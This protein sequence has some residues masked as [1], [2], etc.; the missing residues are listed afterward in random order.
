MAQDMSYV[1]ALP[2][3]SHRLVEATKVAC[4][5]RLENALLSELKTGCFSWLQRRGLGFE[6][7]Q[8]EVERM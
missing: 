4:F 3:C 5:Q 1:V 7:I 2:Y 8:K 6:R